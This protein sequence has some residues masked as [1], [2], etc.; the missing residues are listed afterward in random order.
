MTTILISVLVLAT[1]AF[2]ELYH[3]NTCTTSS[4][5]DSTSIPVGAFLY[6]WY[7][8]ATTGTGGP[9]SPG[10]NSTSSPGGGS[11]VD[12]P[13][14]GYYVSDSDSTFK[15]QVS[16]MQCAGISFAVVSWWGS[17]STGE[18]GAINKATLDL[19]RYLASTNSTFRVAI[20][21]DAYQVPNA[22]L[23]AAEFAQDYSYTSSTF[24]QPFNSSYFYWE[25]KPLLLFF[26]PIIP[27]NPDN[28]NF[29]IRSMGNRP[30]PVQWTF[31]DA[32]ASFLVSQAGSGVN[33]TN[34]EGNPVI[35]SDGEVTIVPRIDSY[36]NRG[37]QGD[38]YLR[39]DPTLSAGLYAEQ[40]SYVISH[41]SEVKLVLIYSFNEY[42]ERSEIELHD[43][44]ANS[45]VGASYLLDLT[46]QFTKQLTNST[47]ASTISSIEQPLGNTFSFLT[48]PWLDAVAI[49]V[50]F[51]VAFVV[52]F[53]SRG[54][55]NGGGEF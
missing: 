47:E 27:N 7:G 48:D 35:S 1:F 26:N 16:Q 15:T 52:W 34:D 5:A 25:G 30:N 14:D 20:M 40:W 8:N 54:G 55:G 53:V 49:S 39:F 37:S 24:V 4:S 28:T 22:N 3:P 43:D 23:T 10:W 18:N 11:V 32:P 12:K 17:S 19:F 45:T 38:S 33:A 29:T 50:A 13:S 21:V 2:V 44:Y 41:R 51:V 31:W 9:G 36:Y 6:L 42:H 46:T